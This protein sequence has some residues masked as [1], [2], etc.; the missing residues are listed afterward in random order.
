[1][2]EQAKQIEQQAQY[3]DGQAYYQELERARKLRDAA[4]KI[5]G[6]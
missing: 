6:I 1:M 5:L 4:Y 3:A 2:L